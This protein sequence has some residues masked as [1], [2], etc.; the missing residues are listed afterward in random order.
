MKMKLFFPAILLIPGIIM[1][2]PGVPH[3][4]ESALA[5][6]EHAFQSSNPA[7]IEDLLPMSM[8]LRLGDSLYLN[9]SR[10]TALDLLKR[11]FSDRDSVQFHFFRYLRAVC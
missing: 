5:R 4:V 9:V 7:S 10:I 6:I 2:Q 3:D 8:L 1:A 11:F